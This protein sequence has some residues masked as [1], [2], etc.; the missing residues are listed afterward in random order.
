LPAKSQRAS[1][2][3]RK[4][5]V[6][7]LLLQ[8]RHERGGHLGLVFHDKNIH[9]NRAVYGARFLAGNAHRN[10]T[11]QGTVK[12]R[13]GFVGPL[14]FEP[15]LPGSEQVSL[16]EPGP[17]EILASLAALRER[18]SVTDHLR[19]LEAASFATPESCAYSSSLN[20]KEAA[21]TFSSRWGIDEVPAI[22]SMIGDRFS[23]Q[24]SAT[25]LGVLL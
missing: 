16:P 9:E 11:L 17:N 2:V 12:L 23:N 1:A 14:G 18:T 7:K 15:L 10:A 21:S 19:V 13:I 4:L 24:A 6:E 3:L 20:R 5:N 8:P 22:G 25:C